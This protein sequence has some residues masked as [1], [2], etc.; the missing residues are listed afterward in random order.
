MDRYTVFG[1]PIAQSKSPFIHTLF[2]QQ[3]E[4]A[5]TYS[6][7][8]AEEND[9]AHAVQQFRQAGGCGAN[10][11]APFKQ[12]AAAL[13]DQLSERAQQAGAVNTLIWLADGQLRGDNT[14][15]AGLVGDLQ[16]LGVDLAGKKIVI[17]GAG[18]AVRGVLGPML[19]QQPQHIRLINRTAST[20]VELAQ[21][22]T[23]LGSIDG[24][25]LTTLDGEIDIIINGTSASLTG[26]SL[27]LPNITVNNHCISY[28][29]SYGTQQT[30]FQRWGQQQGIKQ[31]FSGVGMLVQQAAVS[32]EL[33]RQCQPAIEPVL[34]QVIREM[35]IA[36]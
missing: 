32:F 28:D 18:G 16:R 20:A 19:A 25:G 13:C 11:T 34:Q 31:N 2:A 35:R 23:H 33:W 10:V 22:F 9:F 17:L 5:L 12:Q 27:A 14:D 24:G 26:S 15:G 4:Q 6:A 29:M 8:L 21:M 36:P 30:A 3:T 7:T 1:N